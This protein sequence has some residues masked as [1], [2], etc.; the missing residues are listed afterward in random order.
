MINAEALTVVLGGEHPEGQNLEYDPLYLELDTLAVEVP[1]SF[2]G[3]SKHQ[4]RD[5]DWKKLSKNCLELW[6]KTRDLRVA[7]YLVIAEAIT[8]G[9]T[10][11]V[12][13]LKLPVFLVKELWDSFYPQ[14]DA[15]YD[16]DPLERLNILAMLSPQEGSIND[17]VMFIPRFREIRLVPSLK[18]TLRDLLISLNEIEVRDDKALDPKLLRAEL[19]NLGVGEIEAQAALVKEGQAL[20]AE[21]C[22]TMNGKMKGSYILDMSALSHELNRLHTFYKGHLESLTSSSG[23]APEGVSDTGVS[24]TTAPS[25]SSS[26]EKISLLS[27]HAATRTEALLLLKKGAE[28]FQSQEPNSPIPHLIDRALRFSEMSF[29]E[30]LEDI[31]PDALSRGRD[32][33]GIKPE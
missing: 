17:P 11:L 14:F 13:G 28:Y 7:V 4:G 26:G 10:G 33:L 16:D 8:G 31:V 15:E 22:E 6:K 5:P 2:I 1:D 19:M 20:I 23:E 18:Y 30:L 12:A 32:I 9:L 3:E 21:L 24:G 25:A 29:I 27:Y